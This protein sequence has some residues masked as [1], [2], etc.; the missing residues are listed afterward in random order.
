VQIFKKEQEAME[1][2]DRRTVFAAG[3]AAKS[4]AVFSGT[5]EHFTASA[6]ATKLPRASF[7]PSRNTSGRAIGIKEL[8]EQ[9]RDWRK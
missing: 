9:M 6:G 8:F 1:N 3:L 4:P 7:T 2:I 5:W